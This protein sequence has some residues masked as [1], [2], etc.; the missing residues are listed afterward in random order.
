MVHV[1]TVGVRNFMIFV[2]Y[3]I[4][5][6]INGEWKILILLIIN[7]EFPNLLFNKRPGIY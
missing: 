1:I 3:T 7:S 5:S 6:L 2:V 4:K